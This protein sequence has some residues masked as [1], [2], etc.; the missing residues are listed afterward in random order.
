ML[1]L[2]ACAP[3]P[4]DVPLWPRR[5]DEVD[6]EVTARLGEAETAWTASVADHGPAAEPM[7]GCHALPVP[8]R[9]EGTFQAVFV[10]T[11]APTRLRW[12]A[13]AA[14]WSAEGPR[15]SVDPAW[16]VGS[17]SWVRADGSTV[18]ADGAV[19]FGGLPDVRALAH[20]EDGSIRLAYAA[21]PDRVSVVAKGVECVGG[22]TS[23]TVPWYL[24]TDGGLVLR[25]ARER[26]AIVPDQ[27]MIHVRAVL[28][29]TLSLD[30]PL[31]THDTPT[32]H[33]PRVHDVPKLLTGWV[34]PTLG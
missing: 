3:R 9:G 2:L 22:P 20:E 7:R 30:A 23:L 31:Q 11:P 34:E 18:D 16:A 19:R 17:L 10:D 21:T 27:G 15:G 28:E 29:R 14:R 33:A 8:V 32:P 5:G 6:V 1:F 4:A 25:S 26:T 13:D 12:D 24:V